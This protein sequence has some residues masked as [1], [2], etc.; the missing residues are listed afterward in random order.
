MYRRKRSRKQKGGDLPL[1]RHQHYHLKKTLARLGP[2]Y[3]HFRDV[4]CHAN[5]TIDRIE[6]VI[7][8]PDLILEYVWT[9]VALPHNDMWFLS[10]NEYIKYIPHAGSVANITGQQNPIV[11]NTAQES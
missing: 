2:S 6:Q 11:P 9:R 7:R 10:N 1:T 4:W 3:H 8:N 5:S